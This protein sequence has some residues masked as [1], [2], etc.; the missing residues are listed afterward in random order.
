MRI[1]MYRT[2][3]LS[4]LICILCALFVPERLFGQQPRE[5]K[6]TQ[7]TNRKNA[8][9][10]TAFDPLSVE[11]A[12][13]HF[14]SLLKGL[15]LDMQ[16]AETEHLLV[17]SDLEK[18][19]TDSIA[20]LAD[21]A[22]LSACRLLKIEDSKKLFPNKVVV[23]VLNKDEYFE[24]VQQ[25]IFE[26]PLTTS[27]SVLWRTE[28]ELPC[29]LVSNFPAYKFRTP[30]FSGNWSQF[31]ARFVGTLVLL[32]RYP[33]DATHSRVPVW[34][35]NGFGLYASLLAQ[36]SPQVTQSYRDLFRERLQDKVKLFDFS[37]GTKEFYNYHVASVVEYLYSDSESDRF[38][39]L[40]QA[41]QRQK[42]VHDDRV[43]MDL[44]TELEWNPVAME[45]EWR[46]FAKTGKR[47]AR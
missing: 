44:P 40:L 7:K 42:V 27:R 46:F 17:F 37:T 33:T 3:K 28:G 32:Q 16:I 35:R 29:L 25:A 38:D 15:K 23:V 34:A 2:F 24:R 19:E 21:K 5:P 12:R 13:K 9:A 22:F 10:E 1:I 6:G 41:L 11:T 20:A 18:S 8:L 31:T 36:D 4:F 39:Q 26:S 30:G 47:L 14:A 45:R 43:F